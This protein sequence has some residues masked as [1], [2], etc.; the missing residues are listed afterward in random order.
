MKC[1]APYFGICQMV[2]EHAWLLRILT[3]ESDCMNAYQNTGQEWD[4]IL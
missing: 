2:A 4:G 1:R 3:V